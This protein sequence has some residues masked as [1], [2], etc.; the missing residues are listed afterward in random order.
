MRK[1]TASKTLSILTIAL[2]IV[3]IGPT[4]AMA[5]S[6]YQFDYFSNNVPAAPDA[7]VYIANSTNPYVTLCAMIYVFDPSEFMTTCCGCLVAPFGTLQLSVRNN[8]TVPQIGPR[9]VFG[10]IKIVSAAA[11][12]TTCDPTMSITPTVGLRAW[13][14]HI[15]KAA[16]RNDYQITE[17]QFAYFPLGG[18]LL[19]DLES[20][21]AGRTAPQGVCT[22]Y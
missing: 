10:Q 7:T 11:T 14:T 9:P 12:G 8:L 6:P 4:V 21:C 3:S 15:Q 17:A 20:Q 2:L 5:Q 18:S 19:A 22:C 16:K 1:E 13:A